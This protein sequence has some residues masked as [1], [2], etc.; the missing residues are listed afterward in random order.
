M[1]THFFEV[2]MHRLD[3]HYWT[4]G[5]KIEAASFKTAIDQAY[6]WGAAVETFSTLKVHWISILTIANPERGYF[7]LKETEEIAKELQLFEAG[8]QHQRM[9]P[10]KENSP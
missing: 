7:A 6:A 1:Y 4:M 9:T 2:R 5:L 10:T 3:H 8:S